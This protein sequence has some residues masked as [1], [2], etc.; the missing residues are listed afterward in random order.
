LFA[1]KA[2][3]LLGMGSGYIPSKEA[4]YETPLG[5]HHI[6]FEFF[7]HL[8]TEFVPC[9][10]LIFFTRKQ[11]EMTAGSASASVGGSSG[12]MRSSAG[13]GSKPATPNFSLRMRAGSSN[14]GAS[15]GSTLDDSAT[16]IG[17]G[18]NSTG[19]TGYQYQVRRLYVCMYV[20]VC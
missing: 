6:S 1:V 14:N 16:T 11:H 8:S 5:V 2:V 17:T 9:A 13:T 15:T 10:L 18:N 12:P 3:Y 19:L 20:C 4:Q 7:I